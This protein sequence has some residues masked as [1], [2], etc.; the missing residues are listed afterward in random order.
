[1]AEVV[2]VGTGTMIA[3]TTETGK[4]GMMTVGTTVTGAEGESREL[5][6]RPELTR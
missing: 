4:G 6:I 2:E 5:G 1:M 3:E